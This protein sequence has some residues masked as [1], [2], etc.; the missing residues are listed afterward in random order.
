[1]ETRKFISGALRCIDL[2]K[3]VRVEYGQINSDGDMCACV[4]PM[5]IVAAVREMPDSERRRLA[6]WLGFKVTYQPQVFS[7]RLDVFCGPKNRHYGIAAKLA[8]T[9]G[10][11]DMCIRHWR[12]G[13]S[14]P[15]EDQARRIAEA[16]G[17]DVAEA[18]ADLRYER[19]ERAI[20]REEARRS[21]ATAGV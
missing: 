8:K 5:D 15:S 17:W 16:L 7:S 11:S 10:V 19:G 14:L 4:I 1:M 13:H 6:G 3:S 18:L 20:R 21:L 2:G 9:L 12:A